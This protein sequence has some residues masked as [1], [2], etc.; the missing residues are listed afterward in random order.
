VG[1]LGGRSRARRAQR[2]RLNR[3]TILIPMAW[4]DAIVLG[5]RIAA[6]LRSG[7]LAPAEYAATKRVY[8][9]LARAGAADWYHD[10]LPK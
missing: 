5:Q 9:E 4:D 3:V 8:D 10:V 7:N 1:A 2:R 6:L